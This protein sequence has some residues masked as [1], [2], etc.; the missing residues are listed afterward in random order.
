VRPVPRTLIGWT[1]SVV[2]EARTVFGQAAR[3]TKVFVPCRTK[4]LLLLVCIFPCTKRTFIQQLISQRYQIP[5]K[6]HTSATHGREPIA[7]TH[8]MAIRALPLGLTF[9]THPF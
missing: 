8:G 4:R 9:R 5:G 3:L 1:G 6:L 2:C 7:L